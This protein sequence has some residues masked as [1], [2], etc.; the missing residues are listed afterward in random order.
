[1][2]VSLII[3]RLAAS[4]VKLKAE[5]RGTELEWKV[6]KRFTESIFKRDVLALN[7][8]AFSRSG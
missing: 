3:K 8:D 6:A 2:F 7:L 4:D 1:M 5:K